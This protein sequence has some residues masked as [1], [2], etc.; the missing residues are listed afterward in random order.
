[1]DAATIALRRERDEAQDL[2]RSCEVLPAFV[3]V[4]IAAGDLDAA[5]D[6]AARLAEAANTLGAPYVRALAAY[7]DGSVLVAGGEARAALGPL[8]LALSL[9]RE[10]DA[11]YE[12]AR[13]RTWIGLA[14]RA[15][16]DEDAA[17]LEF[18]AA[19]RAFEKLGA[20]PLAA[21]SPAAAVGGLSPREV[22]VV[23]L[24]A[25]GK[26]NRAIASQL[27]ISEKTVARHVSNI[28]AKL[29]VS[30]RAAATAYAYEHGLLAGRT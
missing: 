19:R 5:R 7:A 10:L 3:E 16:G 23:R 15:I 4:M 21:G 12:T 28:F 17:A 20:T 14:C 18:D 2:S 6:G 25:A 9:W 30:T 24:L 8:R 13:T 22:E 26:S 27:F 29:G 1:M 11:P